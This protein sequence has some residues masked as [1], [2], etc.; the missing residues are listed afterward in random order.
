MITTAA[1]CPREGPTALTAATFKLF[2]E[3]KG[4]VQ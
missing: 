2:E 4:R 3:P 1:D